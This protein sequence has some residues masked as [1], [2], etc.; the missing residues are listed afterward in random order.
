LKTVAEFEIK[1]CQFLDAEGNLAPGA[2]PLASDTGELLKMYRFMTLARIFDSKAIN[3]QRTGKLGTYASC[4][5]HEATHVGVAAAMQPDDVLAPVYREFGSQIWR[6][7]KMSSI[8]LYWGGDER[9]SHFTAARQDFAWCVPI[10]SQMLHGAGVA[11]AMKIK[12]EKRCSVTYIGDGGTS[13]GAFYEGINVAG[14][15]ALPAVFVIVNNRWAISVPIEAQTATRTLAQKAVAAGIPGIQVDGNDV[16]AV[17]HTVSEAVARARAGDGPT[18][19][20]AL[21]Y[22]L[23]DHT[24]AD[25]ASRYRDPR[26]VKDAW[27]R[28]PLLRLRAYLTKLRIW[29]DAREEELKAECAREVE[30]AVDEYL[31][32]PKPSTDEMFDHL[33]ARPPQSLLQQRELARRYAG[34]HDAG[35]G[36]RGPKGPT[37]DTTRDGR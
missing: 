21:T 2:P 12:G 8:L 15:R 13:E 31:G 20:E 29:D 25:D 27:T 17:R 10:A 28:E 4:L 22:R 30:A 14:A 1:Y 32:A 37:G 18:L 24:T 5:G 3:L 9:G 11:M 34:G 7:V 16:I 35:V 33:F 6:G 19:I 23:S 36:N 26:E